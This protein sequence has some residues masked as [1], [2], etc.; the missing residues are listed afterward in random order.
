MDIGTLTSMLLSA[1][2]TRVNGPM[3]ERGRHLVGDRWS[4]GQSSKDRRRIKEGI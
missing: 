1:N 4:T 2:R 3:L